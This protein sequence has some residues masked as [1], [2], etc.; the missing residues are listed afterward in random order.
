MGLYEVFI[1]YQKLIDGLLAEFSSK[2]GIALKDIYMKCRDVADG[3]FTALFEEH[4]YQWF[5]DLMMSW[6]SFDE[7]L[8]KIRNIQRYS[9]K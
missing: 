5:L 6:T 1:E 8:V 9:K 4:E 3:K 2:K 7:F